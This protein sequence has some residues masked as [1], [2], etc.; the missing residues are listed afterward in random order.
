M[1]TNMNV[2]IAEQICQAID[3]IVGERL[4][5]INYD[6]T[7]IATIENNKEAKDCKYICSNGSTEFV[8]FSKDT[9][10]KV[11][12]TVQVT[13]PNNDY[14]QQ[15]IIIG[16][17][18]AKNSTPFAYVQPFDTFIDVSANVVNTTKELSLLANDGVVVITDP[19]DENKKIAENVFT[20]AEILYGISFKEG[21]EGFNRMGI[22]GQFRSWLSELKTIKGDYGYRV[23]LFSSNGALLNEA[24][25]L[26]SYHYALLNIYTNNEKDI[27][28]S[29]YNFPND[30]F[31]ALGEGKD[32][33]QFINSF[34]GNEELIEKQEKLLPLIKSKFKLTSLYLSSEEMYGNPFNF[35]NFYEQE[36]VYDISKLGTIYG[37]VLYFYEKTGSFYDELNVPIPYQ[38]SGGGLRPNNLFTKDA[39]ICFGY[40]LSGFS[41]E[42][43]ILYSLSGET[44]DANN[45]N[46]TDKEN[47]KLIRLRWLHEFEDGQIKV[48]NEST[49]LD[50]DYEIRWYRYQLGA[51][52]ADEYS[53]VYW[54]RVNPSDVSQFTYTLNPK[55]NVEREQIKAIVL[56]KDKVIESNIITFTA[57]NPD[58]V[59]NQATAKTL[60]GLSIWCKDNSY[61]NY[62]VYGQN[63][64][65][66]ESSTLSANTILTLEARFADTT[67]LSTEDNVDEKSPPLKSAKSITW[68]FPLRDTMIVVD[69]INYHPD[70]PEK[71]NEKKNWKLPGFYS[72][73]DVEGDEENGLIKITRYG[74]E[75]NG[76]EINATQNY[77]IQNFYNASA[78]NNTI[79]C[80][81]E[82][83]S[84]R[85]STSK[86]F[87]FGIRGTSGTD[88]TL[89]INFDNNRTAFT[90]EPYINDE[91]DTTEIYQTLSLTARLFDSS[92]KEIDFVNDEQY[93]HLSCSW[94]W[95]C[96]H[97]DVEGSYLD[98]S[99]TKYKIVSQELTARKTSL[100]K[101]INTL[102]QQLKEKENNEIYQDYLNLLKQQETETLTEDDEKQLN[103]LKEELD[104]TFNEIAQINE[105]IKEAEA[106][107]K[108]VEDLYGALTDDTIEFTETHSRQLDYSYL[109]QA[110]SKNGDI[111]I[112]E[113]KEDQSKNTCIIGFSE[114]ATKLD[115]NK[116]Y[117]HIIKFTITG[118]A[119]YPELVAY[120]AIPIRY[121]QRFRN[122]IGPVNITYDTKGEIYYNKVPY[123]LYGC[124]NKT[125]IGVSADVVIN[126]SSSLSL[127]GVTWMRYNPY[128]EKLDLIGSFGT[129]KNILQPCALY[130]KDTKPYGVKAYKIFYKKDEAGNL[131]KDEKGNLIV[132]EQVLAWIQPLVITQNKYPS[133]TINSWNGKGIEID[134]KSGTI[135]APA[136]AAGKKHL[137]DNTFS[138]V[139]IGD[140]K[141][142]EKSISAMTGVYGFNH[143][144]QSFAFKEDGTAFIGK[145]G[146]GRILFDGNKGILKSSN[147]DKDPSEGM[148]LDLD[149]GILDMKA[150]NK[151]ITLSADEKEWPLAIGNEQ[152]VSSRDFRVDWDGYL[153]AN[154]ATISGTIHAD[155]GTLGDLEVTGTLDC[156]DGTILG[157]EII[158]GTISGAEI[159]FGDGEFYVYEG[160]GRILKLKEDKGK[161]FQKKINNEWVTFTYQS[162]QK[163]TNAGRLLYGTGSYSFEDGSNEESG[164]LLLDAT[165]STSL[166]ESESLASLPIIVRSDD[167]VLIYST[168]SWV[169]LQTKT[170]K[171]KVSIPDGDITLEANNIRFGGEAASKPENQHNIYARFA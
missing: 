40:D 5:S 111:I 22:R 80:E 126:D 54:V 79:T 1:S 4:K 10:Y 92:Y 166:E 29:L 113:P 83:N 39:Y 23:D 168:N 7:I 165:A 31:T 142:A 121:D 164:V 12:E 84:M 119:D 124:E 19:N 95:E 49:Q 159:Y 114:K 117:F 116:N 37:L 32:K 135:V 94:S 48:V 108:E 9:T 38:F 128:N 110:I 66:L 170:A 6:T 123:E 67:I 20:K 107:K 122:I 45:D 152:S 56:Y 160:G 120:K 129:T 154:N 13:I 105:Q 55:P 53:G 132:E 51:K 98:P 82:K 137:E 96:Y 71:E 90:A 88:V 35:Q 127:D 158:G 153:K 68:T 81:I 8:A 50:G 157:A 115:L 104:I 93:S 42:Q 16:K 73:A 162:T 156:E 167:R 138:G 169:M 141:D 148:F 155:S 99:T 161:T 70:E 2:D 139:M 163:A 46:I 27:R 41:E 146:S 21:Y 33:T 106:S 3:S 69:G 52:Q 145:S 86:E 147:W 58:G 136:I 131:I 65:I 62:F 89:V 59:V 26:D 61:G 101:T 72:D 103:S 78:I 151:F 133:A 28:S 75:N 43:A 77:L 30:W 63:N 125:D 130:T 18:V 34:N 118:W 44:F 14:D 109:D 60:S 74:N 36:K 143:G 149:N 102:N 100:E 150:N 15:K 140:W 11:G 87:N 144:A 91:T 112:Y 17:Y 57:Q 47:E 85:P 24:Q 76:Y 171:I 97:E 64:E 25:E 134:D